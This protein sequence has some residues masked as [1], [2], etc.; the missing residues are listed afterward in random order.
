[1][2]TK[3]D[4]YEVLGVSRD[5]TD[6]AIK[7]AFRRLAFKYHP[8]HNNEDGAT[9]KFKEVNQ[10]YEILADPDRRA[11]YDSYG[12]SGADGG[13]G[14]GFTSAGF[15]GLGDI[16]DAFF[17]GTTST[18]RHGPQTGDSLRYPLEI[19]LEEA[20]F[21]CEKEITVTRSQHC[22]MCQGTGSRPGS[23]PRRCANCNGTGQIRRVQQS[24]FGRFV[25]TTTCSQCRGEGSVITDHCPQCHGSGREQQQQ[26]VTINIPAGVDGNSQIRLSG[27]GDA[28]TRGGPPGDL[29]I[30]LD[31]LPHESFVRDGDDIIHELAINFPQA[32]LGDKVAVPTLDGTTELKIPAGSQTGEVFRL[33]GKGVPHLRHHGRGDQLVSLFVATPE[34]LDE[35]QRQLIKKLADSLGPGRKREKKRSDFWARFNP[36]DG[37]GKT[38]KRR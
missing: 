28:G 30:N 22:A 14:P 6:E 32:A 18:K 16:F 33:K 24:I 38:D 20:A 3:R 35:E 31:V 19:T 10:A 36:G 1:M 37:K 8:D 12:H 26:P 13:F 17:G 7:K 25:N 15:G 11:S 21:G 9:E 2:P 29:Y 4:Y 34:S 27:G 5:A 23:Q